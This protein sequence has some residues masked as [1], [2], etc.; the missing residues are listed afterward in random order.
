[1]NAGGEQ[2]DG[3]RTV[4]DP[5]ER[6]QA[7]TTKIRELQSMVGD[8]KEVRALAIATLH[9]GGMSYR[10]IG[11]LTG[12]SVQRVA[13][14]GATA[15]SASQLLRAWG[16]VE[17][18]LLRLADSTGISNN[19]N[20]PSQ[21]IDALGRAGHLGPD[22][23]ELLKR[24]RLARSRAVHGRGIPPIEEQEGLCD[25]AIVL[26]SRLEL[27]VQESIGARM[28]E[29][30]DDRREAETI[31]QRVRS[32]RPD[33]RWVQGRCEQCG[34][35]IPVPTGPGDWVCSKSC[36]DEWL[37]LLYQFIDPGSGEEAITRI[38]R[39]VPYWI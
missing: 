26:A 37:K 8:L 19:V 12:L 27:K 9:E 25:D 30:T 15:A 1:M 29:M 31:L 28:K 20:T 6:Y 4:P 34:R 39:V 23:Q 35:A 3:I 11:A 10:E 7:A 14:M 5:L 2:I 18:Q 17:K 32:D 21:A 24:L 22:D 13:Q 16:A 33:I 38:P 36:R